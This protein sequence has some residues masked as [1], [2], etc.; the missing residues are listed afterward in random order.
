MRVYYAVR[1]GSYVM[2]YPRFLTFVIALLAL[3]LS[4]LAGQARAGG[5]A[6]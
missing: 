1:E 3:P 5:A 4:A 6:R 2:R